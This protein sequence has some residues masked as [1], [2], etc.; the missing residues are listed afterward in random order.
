[1]KVKGSD[2]HIL[3]SEK[4]PNATGKMV[5]KLSKNGQTTILTTDAQGDVLSAAM[6]ISNN[7][8]VHISAL[9]KLFINN[10]SVGLEGLF[11]RTFSIFTVN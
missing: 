4:N 2:A 5:L 7:G 3:F 11:P 1:M 6:S 8:N 9:D 10:T